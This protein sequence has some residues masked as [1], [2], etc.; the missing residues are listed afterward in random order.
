MRE[1]L[2]E[3]GLGELA[4]RIDTN[5]TCSIRPLDGNQFRH[6]RGLS[7][8]ELLSICLYRNEG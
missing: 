2:M 5:E 1:R 4:N 7:K 6:A 3:R 8:A